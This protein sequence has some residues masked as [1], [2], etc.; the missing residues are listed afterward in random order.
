[1]GAINDSAKLIGEALDLARKDILR[2]RQLHAATARLGLVVLAE[3]LDDIAVR[4][5]EEI[6]TIS[7]NIM[8]ILQPPG[9]MGKQEEEDEVEIGHFGGG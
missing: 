9:M 7:E 5:A 6:R 4:M 2:L 1:M 8:E 3:E